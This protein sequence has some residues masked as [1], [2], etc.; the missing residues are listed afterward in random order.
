MKCRNCG[1]ENKED[2]LFCMD[3]GHDLREDRDFSKTEIINKDHSYYEEDDTKIVKNNSFKDNSMG[4]KQKGLVFGLVIVGL[5]VFSL[6]FNFG[7]SKYKYSKLETSAKA[8]LEAKNYKEAREKFSQLYEKSSDKKYL[9]EINK[10]DKM[11]ETK[12]LLNKA[13]KKYEERDYET[14]LA[15]LKEIQTEDDDELREKVDGLIK[16][17]Y[18]G[19]KSEIMQLKAN[20]NYEGAINRLNEYLTVDPENADFKKMLE[21]LNLEK[22]NNDNKAQEESEAT[23]QKARADELEAQIQRLQNRE[24]SSLVGT[25][26]FVTSG[27]ANVRSGPGFVYSISYVLH[28]G[29]PVYVYDTR[30]SDGRTWCNIGDGWISYRTLNG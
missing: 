26:Q 4:L 13:N 28:R 30:R 6:I 20:N 12:D 23:K 24:V 14:S 2:A 22:T 21:D 15:N 27:K 5:I 8:N 11:L 9:D 10:I 29:D 1:K 17:N 18:D 7:F 19:I 3:C 25:Y 16:K